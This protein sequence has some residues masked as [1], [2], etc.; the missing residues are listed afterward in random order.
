MVDGLVQLVQAIGTFD[1]C[2]RQTIAGMPNHRVQFRQEPVRRVFQLNHLI[3]PIA[4][5]D[6]HAV[7][8]CSK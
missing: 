5:F 6:V 8:I 4:D 3:S 2:C 7:E 1:L